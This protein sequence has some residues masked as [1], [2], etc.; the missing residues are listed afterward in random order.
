MPLGKPKGPRR[1]PRVNRDPLRRV[2]GYRTMVP[3][4]ASVSRTALPHEVYEC[5]HVA[6][7]KADAIGETNAVRR[8]CHACASGKPPHLSAAELAELDS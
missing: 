7:P 4:G 5:G 8:R 1:T 2:V 3:P 6:L